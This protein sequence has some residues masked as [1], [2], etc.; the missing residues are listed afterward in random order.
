[1]VFPNWQVTGLFYAYPPACKVRTKF[2][3]TRHHFKKSWH[4]NMKFFTHF[5]WLHQIYWLRPTQQ[6]WLVSLACS[7]FGMRRAKRI[8]MKRFLDNC[9]KGL[10]LSNWKDKRVVFCV[11]DCSH[12]LQ[13]MRR[14][15]SA[16][17]KS[18]R[19]IVFGVRTCM[20]G[21]MR[22]LV[23]VGLV[24]TPT[25]VSIAAFCTNQKTNMSTSCPDKFSCDPPRRKGVMSPNACVRSATQV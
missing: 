23:L 18:K 4:F 10:L 19:W 11:Q 14:S 12:R 20:F 22:I 21:A 13:K 17:C 6:Q 2:N 1:M 25:Q 5:H 24:Y 9:S 8:P 3:T 16:L 15:L 7:S